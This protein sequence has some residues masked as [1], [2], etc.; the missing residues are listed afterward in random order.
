MFW[1][2]SS[3]LPIKI[4]SF[5]L[6]F[7]A[8]SISSRA[9]DQ[10]IDFS[11]V[12]ATLLWVSEVAEMCGFKATTSIHQRVR[13]PE[14]KAVRII[15]GDFQGEQHCRLSRQVKARSRRVRWEASSNSVGP[16]DVFRPG[17][18]GALKASV[19]RNHRTSRSRSVERRNAASATKARLVA[20]CSRAFPERHR[21]LALDLLGPGH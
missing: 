20:R 12:R 11:T 6:A 17:D 7:M 10:A 18:E 8:P 9:M 13:C 21:A 2:A 1:G 19:G 5:L 15:R 14:G 16:G 4:Q 3:L